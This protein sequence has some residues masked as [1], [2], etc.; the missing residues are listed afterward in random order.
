MNSESIF[1]LIRVFSKI[2]LS[3][4]IIISVEL[5]LTYIINLC[6]EMDGFSVS[7][8]SEILIGDNGWTWKLL[9][10]KM[11]QAITIFLILFIIDTILSIV[12]IIRNKK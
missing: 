5:F 2:L 1:R 7:T 10:G 11:S 3:I 8:F 9:Y 4:S 12:S 6:P